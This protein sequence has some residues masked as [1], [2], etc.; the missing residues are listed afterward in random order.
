MYSHRNLNYQNFFI[1]PFGMKIITIYTISKS[2]VTSIIPVF[3]NFPV[4]RPTFLKV[5]GTPKNFRL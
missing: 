3:S 4:S 2:V 1:V 5:L